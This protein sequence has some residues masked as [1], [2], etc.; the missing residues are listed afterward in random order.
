ME[1]WRK[2]AAYTHLDNLGSTAFAWEFLRRNSDYR[3]AF[4]SIMCKDDETL[5]TRRWGCAADPNLRADYAP[6]I[7]LSVELLPPG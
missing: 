7:T 2:A 6:I 5:I 1:N 3:T 4:N